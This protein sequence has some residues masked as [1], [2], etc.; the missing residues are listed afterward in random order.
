MKN[1]VKFSLKGNTNIRNLLKFNK[2]NLKTLFNKRS[3]I[4]SNKSRDKNNNY[5]TDLER[6]GSLRV[7]TESLQF[8]KSKI[9]DNLGEL[10]FG[11]IPEPLKYVRDFK[12]TVLS[13]G[14]RVC[15]ESWNT[16]TSAVGVYINSGSR[17]ETQETCGSAHFLEH[18]LFKGTKNRQKIQ[19]EKEIENSGSTLDAYTSREHTLF[20]MTCFNKNV[21]NCLDILS[22]MVRNPTLSN[23]AITEEKDTII[24]ELEHSNKDPQE[25]IMEA[26]HFNS[27]RDHM[28]GSPI[29]GD[30]DNIQ[31][32]TREMVSNYY[33]TNYV[34]ENLIIIGTGGVN[35]EAFVAEVS[36]KFGE[37]SR[38][39]SSELVRPNT[40]KPHY[41]PSVMYMRDDELYNSAI[42][43][44]YDAPSWNH[45][46]YYTF[47]ILER[48]LG[49]YQIDRNGAS[50]LNEPSKQYSAM[51]SVL[52]QLP[53]VQKA[54]AIYSPYK[55]CGLFGTYF[56]GNEA[57]TRW[58][59]Y[60]GIMLP[61]S[62]GF[63]PNQVEVS[64]ARAKLY[65]DLLSIQ[66]PA[67]VLQFIGPQIQYL[68]RRVHRSE[69]AKRVAHINSDS[70]KRVCREW[71][72]D[73]EPSVV[74]YG[75]IESLSGVGSYR[76]IKMNSHVSCFNLAHSLSK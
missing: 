57:F 71:L 60:T 65:S 26:A 75:P 12:M 36:K 68:N 10:P 41:T 40:H 72:Y 76:Y 11:E 45:E 58:M 39:A 2:I 67:D 24:S 66:S 63:S 69:I 28:I 23:Q 62:Y 70:L 7:K 25:T 4:E 3:D 59:T 17:Y 42:G 31:N 54:T 61:A 56:Y 34:G 64:R 38:T 5:I 37:M 35:H 51:E 13:N 27:F 74:A 30:I 55:D 15:T 1:L 29:L 33:H 46:D 73:A 8:S 14:I 6:D 43:V 16:P 44:F 53:D 21:N 52:G 47:M 19:F 22:D 49:S 18:L 32:V 48:I 9:M 50:H 20:H